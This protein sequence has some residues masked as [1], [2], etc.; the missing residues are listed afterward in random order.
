M[1]AYDE[2]E[3]VPMFYG[4]VGEEMQYEGDG[5]I[6]EAERGPP[7]PPPE[8]LPDESV[9]TARRRARGRMQKGKPLPSKADVIFGKQVKEYEPMFLKPIALKSR[10]PQQARKA[11][12]GAKAKR[13]KAVAGAKGPDGNA[14]PYLL[15]GANATAPQGRKTP[16]NPRGGALPNPYTFASKPAPVTKRASRTPAS[17]PVSAD[18]GQYEKPAP[19]RRARKPA[20]EGGAFGRMYD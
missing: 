6:D 13:A 12:D 10:Q 5:Y 15:V 8:S 1:S 7:S 9:M 14:S 17:K 3:A 4:G 2:P 11:S 18:S 16:T 20:E 19:P